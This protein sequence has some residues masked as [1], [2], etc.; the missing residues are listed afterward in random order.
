MIKL[1]NEYIGFS[2]FFIPKSNFYVLA[3]PIFNPKL[4]F[5][6]FLEYNYIPKIELFANYVFPLFFGITNII[7]YR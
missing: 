5:L 6:P 1:P 7:F 3:E 4:S 2:G